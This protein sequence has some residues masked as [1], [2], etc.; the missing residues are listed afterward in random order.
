MSTQP[1]LLYFR[2]GS[3]SFFVAFSTPAGNLNDIAYVPH[4]AVALAS[5]NIW[6]S[7]LS[8]IFEASS[9]V[10]AQAPAKERVAPVRSG[11][12]WTHPMR[13]SANGGRE[14]VRLTLMPVPIRPK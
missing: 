10:A 7:E 5:W 13:R 11:V 9:G 14:A 6:N 8:A 2:A 12:M 1:I 3:P 4:A